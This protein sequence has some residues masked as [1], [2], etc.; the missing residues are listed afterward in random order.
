[1]DC[2]SSSSVTSITT[3]NGIKLTVSGTNNQSYYK[4]S[5]VH[6]Y[7]E[8]SAITYNIWKAYKSG[9]YEY[10]GRHLLDAAFNAADTYININYR[11]DWSP[12]KYT[13]DTDLQTL[14][15][16]YIMSFAAIKGD[17]QNPNGYG[18]DMNSSIIVSVD[19]IAFNSDVDPNQGGITWPR[20]ENQ[21]GELNSPSLSLVLVG[22][23]VKDY[24]GGD[25]FKEAYYTVGSAI[26]ELGHAR[27]IWDANHGGHE[28]PNSMSCIMWAEPDPAMLQNP[29]FC[30]GHIIFLKT[31][32]W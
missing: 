13:K 26:H 22:K 27:G 32:H 20:V 6:M 23:I 15:S 25:A 29:L 31:V 4:I 19:D 16:I 11:S 5:E 18:L 30:G 8:N 7:Q 24:S 3:G 10:N 28:D 1:M 17:Y 9:T 12:I 21:S 2:N 14:E